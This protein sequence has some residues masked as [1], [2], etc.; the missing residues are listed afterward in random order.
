MLRDIVFPEENE[1]EFV[2]RAESLGTEAL[3][4]V[5]K[6]DL[7]KLEKLRERVKNL[8]KTTPV[9]LGFVLEAEG[10]DV[11]KVRDLGEKSVLKV[12]GNARELIARRK[13]SM[14]YGLELSERKDFS[15]SRNSGLDRPVCQFAK[16]NNTAVV[17]SFS[18]VLE[19]ADLE[20]LLGRMRQNIVLC[21]KHGLK[22][23]VASLARKPEQ[24]RSLHDLRSFFLVLGMDTLTARKSVES[25]RV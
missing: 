17:F 24:M 12:R 21:R 23:I 11:H 22:V 25:D 20:E 1:E 8:Q 16:K 2:R 15:K 5:Y 3:V 14:V 10:S 4:F 9:R 18:S 19:S 7:S 6:F 13:P